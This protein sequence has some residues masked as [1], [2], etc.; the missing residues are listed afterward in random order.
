M[1]YIFNPTLSD[2]ERQVIT[3]TV[4]G[5]SSLVRPKEGKNAYLIMRSIDKTWLEYKAQELEIFRYNNSFSKENNSFKWRSAC[6]PIFNEFYK[7]F[8][9]KKAR[10]LSMDILD[11]LKDIGLAIWFGDKGT[12]KKG[13]VSLNLSIFGKKGAETTVKYFNEVGI[14]AELVDR[15]VVFTKHG[16]E[17]FIATIG[18]KLP[19]FM[20]KKFQ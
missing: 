4:L 12:C 1:T 7:M 17:R 19:D 16:S 9:Y 11:T 8:I 15:K 18:E 20:H 13:I 3:G 10:R 14:E 5:G 2:W 6:Y